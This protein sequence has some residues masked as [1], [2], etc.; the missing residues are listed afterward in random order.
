MGRELGRKAGNLRGSGLRRI[1]PDCLESGC[2]ESSHFSGRWST[3]GME[4]IRWA[5]LGVAL[6]DGHWWRLVAGYSGRSNRREREGAD[7]PGRMENWRPGSF[8]QRFDGGSSRPRTL[9]FDLDAS[10]RVLA[11]RVVPLR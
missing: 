7:A 2:S 3:A 6:H 8:R 1:Q 11:F 9:A 10:Y 4:L 5:A